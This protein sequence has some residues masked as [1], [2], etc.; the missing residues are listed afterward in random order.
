MYRHAR[1][2]RARGRG[3]LLLRPAGTSPLQVFPLPVPP[4]PLL[5]EFPLLPVFPSLLFEFPLLSV[6][7]VF[8]LPPLLVP[9][10]ALPPL[11][12]PT[13]ALPLAPGLWP[14]PPLLLPAAAAV[15]CSLVCSHKNSI[16]RSM[17]TN[18]SCSVG[19]YL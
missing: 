17:P 15:R 16:S 19:P 3:P 2:A 9:T 11:P 7:L 10:R 18:L 14:L 1:R 4:V 5:L 8:P 13:R 6:F 12:V